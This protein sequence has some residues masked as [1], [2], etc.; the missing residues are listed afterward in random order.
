M[1]RIASFARV[2]FKSTVLLSLSNTP[3]L[4]LNDSSL[5]FLTTVRIYA[6]LHDVLRIDSH[7][8]KV[9]GCESNNM[10]CPLRPNSNTFLQ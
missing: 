7:A 5:A 10:N 2:L 4:V 1:D 9:G 3:S 8:V 6:K